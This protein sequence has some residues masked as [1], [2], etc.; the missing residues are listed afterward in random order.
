[1]RL[2]RLPMTYDD[3]KAR[4]EL[5]YVSRPAAEALAAATRAA[6]GS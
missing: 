6:L 5:G 2:A 4:R 3:G 1:V